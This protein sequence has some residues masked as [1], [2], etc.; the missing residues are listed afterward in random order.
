M[1]RGG[2]KSITNG[3]LADPNKTDHA[4][5]DHATDF[6]PPIYNISKQQGKTAGASLVSHHLRNVNPSADRPGSVLGIS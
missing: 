5:A 4:A 1:P 3:N 2:G 6:D